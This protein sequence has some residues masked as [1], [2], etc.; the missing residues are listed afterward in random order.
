MHWR[1]KFHF[2]RARNVSEKCPPEMVVR[3]AIFWPLLSFF[4]F[5]F[6][7]WPTSKH[8]KKLFASIVVTHSVGWT[9]T[10]SRSW[11]CDALTSGSVVSWLWIISNAQPLSKL[12]YVS[13]HTFD[14]HHGTRHLMESVIRINRIDLSMI[15]RPGNLVGSRWWILTALFDWRLIWFSFQVG[16]CVVWWTADA[17]AGGCEQSARIR[18]GSA[19]LSADEEAGVLR[20]WEPS[21]ISVFPFL[22]TRDRISI[23]YNLNLVFSFTVSEYSHLYR[24]SCRQWVKSF[25]DQVEILGVD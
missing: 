9:G 19:H 20:S 1:S 23:V 7:R 14:V 12:S 3:P 25:Y 16:L 11:R 17:S 5:F 21:L 6:S 4:L 8:N 10:V 18:S 2:I 24:F 15:M 22:N 13:L